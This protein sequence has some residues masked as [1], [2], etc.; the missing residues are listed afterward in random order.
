MI[1]FVLV[2][3]SRMALLIMIAILFYKII[4]FNK[5]KKSLIILFAGLTF[6][7][8]MFMINP[9]LSNRFFHADKNKGIVENFKNWEP[10]LVIW[11]C[12]KDHLKNDDYNIFTGYGSETI[13]NNKLVESYSTQIT[14]IERRNYFLKKKFNPH[15]QYLSFLLSYGIISFLL[16]FLII[17]HSL[18]FSNKSFLKGGV[19]LAFF[20]FGLIESFFE[21]QMGGYIFGLFLVIISRTQL[22]RDT[23]A[24]RNFSKN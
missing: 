1:A 19:I 10:R 16:Y 18:R 2:I 8:V 15:N 17:F 5:N 12:V 9:N 24:I 23:F 6:V 14:K 20:M 3:S 4:C 22:R 11:S 7:T 21:R 13:A